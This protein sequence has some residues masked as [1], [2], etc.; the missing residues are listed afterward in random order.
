M[1]NNVRSF[2]SGSTTDLSRVKIPK[3]GREIFLLLYKYCTSN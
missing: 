3:P 1:D 2:S